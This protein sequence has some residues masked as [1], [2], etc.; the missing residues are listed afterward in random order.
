MLCLQY[1]V[2]GVEF[3]LTLV[4]DSGRD[5][6]KRQQKLKG[7]KIPLWTLAQRQYTEHVEHCCDDQNATAP[8]NP[9]DSVS[10]PGFVT[11]QWMTR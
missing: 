3:L 4:P 6:R 11:F 7:E 1:V 8:I 9:Q 5:N 2:I 10:F